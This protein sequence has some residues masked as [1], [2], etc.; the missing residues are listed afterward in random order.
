[1]KTKPE[2]KKTVLF[3]GLRRRFTVNWDGPSRVFIGAYSK[4]D[5][6]CA[7]SSV[8]GPAVFKLGHTKLT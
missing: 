6:G 8:S 3:D 1:M 4:L 7:L 5:V 2:Q